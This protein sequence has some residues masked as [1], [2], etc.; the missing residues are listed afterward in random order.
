M[1]ANRFLTALPNDCLDVSF[2]SYK[3]LLSY[4][5]YTNP[6]HIRL[7][8]KDGR[9]LF[10]NKGVSPVVIPA[11]QNGTGAGVQWLAY[12]ADGTFKGFLI[13]CVQHLESMLKANPFIAI[14]ARPKTLNS[15][16]KWA[17]LFK[18]RLR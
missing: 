11:E 10:E 1:K 15:W 17:F 6:N 9:K 13:Q 7:W 8:T 12:S 5:N 16:K 14:T 18:A 2:D 4:P 3:V